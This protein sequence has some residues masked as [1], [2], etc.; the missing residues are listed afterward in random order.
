[1]YF[2]GIMNLFMKDSVFF[3]KFRW[4]DF[5]KPIFTI[6]YLSVLTIFFIVIISIMARIIISFKND[7]QISKIDDINIE[8]EKEL[9][10]KE[11]KDELQEENIE[12]Y[13]K[14]EQMIKIENSIVEEA[15]Y[16]DQVSAIY[17]SITEINDRLVNSEN[18]SELFENI[19]A[20]SVHFT[21][22]KKGSLMV[23]DKN[24]EIYVYKA[25][26]WENSEKFK[27]L[28]MSVDSNISGVA[29]LENKIIFIE[30]IENEP[31]FS[32]KFKNEYDT[33]SIISFPIYG[34]NRVVAVVNL[35]DKTNGYYENNDLK[36]I[37]IISKT[38]SRMFEL[39]Q[40]RKKLK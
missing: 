11:Q 27:Y 39:I 36:I 18:I 6:F 9:Q 10:K 8:T 2:L 38:S 5:G 19:L 37:D 22:S 15:N 17:Q 25:I 30:N 26:G 12:F 14:M 16:L 20:V 3:E 28:K 34:I 13:K 29:A 32:F 35:T 4:L 33:K 24:K 31:K 23:I 40:L 21:N 7:S 1:M